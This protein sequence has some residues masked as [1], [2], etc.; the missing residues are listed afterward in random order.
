MAEIATIMAE[1]QFLETHAFVRNHIKILKKH[2]DK[3]KMLERDIFDGLQLLSDTS[4][5]YT[6]FFISTSE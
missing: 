5:Q 2:K 3:R 6:V 1:F 4:A